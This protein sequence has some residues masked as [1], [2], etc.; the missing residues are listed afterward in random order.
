[1]YSAVQN[2]SFDT[3]GLPMG[4]TGR[5][6]AI[7]RPV[8]KSYALAA[9]A[10]DEARAHGATF[11]TFALLSAMIVLIF[12]CFT[13]SV[14]AGGVDQQAPATHD[15]RLEVIKQPGLSG[16]QKYRSAVSPRL[17]GHLRRSAGD[18]VFFGPGSARLGAKARSVLSAQA[19]WMKLR[20]KFGALISGYADDPGSAQRNQDLASKRADAV[21]Q[22]LINEGVDADR[23]VIEA[24][25]RNEAIAVCRSRMCQAQNRRVMTRVLYILPKVTKN[26]EPSFAPNDPSRQ[27]RGVTMNVPQRSL[28]NEYKGA[29]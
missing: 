16:T 21:R 15:W 24:L 13:N 23:I 1:M 6:P 12:A 26:R 5:S 7:N 11:Q 19:Q 22:R 28:G 14:R 27:G 29:R 8:K 25:G 17:T 10:S 3:N 4:R 20:P 9:G 2:S 18:R